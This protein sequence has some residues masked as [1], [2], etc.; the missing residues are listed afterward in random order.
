[1]IAEMAS[2]ADVERQ[3]LA[4]YGDDLPAAPPAVLHVTSAWRRGERLVT[5]RINE[6]APPSAVD[7]FVLNVC[8]ARAD[9]IITTGE[10]LR[11]EPAMH[12]GLQGP[13]TVSR[14]LA[15]WRRERL[16]KI[17]G[18]VSLVL[19]SGRDLDLDHPLFKRATRAVIFTSPAGA[20]RLPG[21]GERG[22]DVVA[23][24][25]A[26]PR[27]ALELVQERY[28]AATVSLESGPSTARLLYQPPLAVDELMLSIYE[29]TELDARARGDEFLSFGKLEEGMRRI[30]KP[31]LA[32]EDEWSFH[33]YRR[34]R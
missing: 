3:L 18:P 25:G 9:A 6:H 14:A 26:S 28:G 24:P 27:R 5:L 8:R 16:G 22:I 23:D 1:M 7:F 20:K 31:Y 29:A 33:R 13:G 34:L 32:P 17:A 10:I 15:E 12:H 30:G 4:M 11:R 2:A 19:T 21:A